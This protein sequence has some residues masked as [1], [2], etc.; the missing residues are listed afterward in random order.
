[1]IQDQTFSRSEA[2]RLARRYSTVS[3]DGKPHP[4]GPRAHRRKM[5]HWCRAI[6]AAHTRRV[7]EGRKTEALLHWDWRRPKEQE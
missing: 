3:T 6:A 5:A 1:M 7:E 4:L 2:L